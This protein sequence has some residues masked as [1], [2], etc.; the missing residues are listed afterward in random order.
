MPIV[1][2]TAVSAK[3]SGNEGAESDQQNDQGD[4]QGGD[5][6]LAEVLRDAVVDLLRGAGV[7]ELAD[8]ETRMRL[9][10]GAH[11]LDDRLDPVHD[12]GVSARYLEPQQRRVPVVGDLA[13]V[14][15]GE[16]ALEGLGV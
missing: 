5:Q 3:S 7:A 10:H 15:R 2:K 14:R 16:R 11:C 13:R 1:A 8:G 12:L 6:S 4:W 9:L